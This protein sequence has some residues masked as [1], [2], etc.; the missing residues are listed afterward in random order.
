MI[1]DE[2]T[3]VL[4]WFDQTKGTPISC[5]R[6]FNAV[7]VNSLWHI[8]SGKREKLNVNNLQESQ[9]LRM[10]ERLLK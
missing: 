6:L 5:N 3:D 10:S 8:V 9:I 7:V 1:L 4:D 2:V